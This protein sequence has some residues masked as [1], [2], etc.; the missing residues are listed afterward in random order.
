VALAVKNVVVLGCHVCFALLTQQLLPGL[1]AV[2]RD[3]D[4]LEVVTPAGCS[5]PDELVNEVH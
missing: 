1:H 3:D 2:S 4:D 5:L